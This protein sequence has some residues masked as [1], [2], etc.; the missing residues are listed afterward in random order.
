MS[1]FNLSLKWAQNNKLSSL[2]WITASNN[3]PTKSAVNTLL[4][5]L[6]N[7]NKHPYLFALSIRD[8]T[9]ETKAAW[10]G[11]NKDPR[12]VNEEVFGQRERQI[13]PHFW[14]KRCPS[15][16]LVKATVSFH[17]CHTATISRK[18]PLFA[19]VGCCSCWI[20][21]RSPEPCE[22]AQHFTANSLRC[23]LVW[24]PTATGSHTHTRARA[25][26]HT[27]LCKTGAGQLASCS[28]FNLA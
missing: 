6:V 26:T 4:W 10:V 21:G 14:T 9:N 1:H 7:L 11:Q 22:A 25:L 5:F 8:W 27:A 2:L 28:S 19:V 23:I 15:D 18:V 3:T 16:V 17:L 20:A 24:Q 12:R 13:L